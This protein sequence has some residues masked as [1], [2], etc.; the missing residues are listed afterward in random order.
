[1]HSFIRLRPDEVADGTA[2]MNESIVSLFYVA[3][4]VVYCISQTRAKCQFELTFV[5]GS[6][7]YIFFIDVILRCT[8]TNL[9]KYEQTLL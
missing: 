9:S 7:R 6:S 1:M 8:G 3:T 5:Y 2:C 4:E